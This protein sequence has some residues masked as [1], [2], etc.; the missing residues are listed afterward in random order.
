M[1]NPKRTDAIMS[2]WTIRH[3]RMHCASPT[4]RPSLSRDG[5]LAV[6]G[7]KEEAGLARLLL[8]DMGSWGRNDG[9]SVTNAIEVL[10][11]EAHQRMV[12]GFNIALADTQIVEL[13]GSGAFDLVLDLGD[14]RG[15]RHQPLF[16]PRRDVLPRS[17]EAFLA[18]GGDV[19]QAMLARVDGL[20]EVGWAG[21]EG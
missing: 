8:A 20:R 19:A 11:R 2:R 3:L 4:A 7:V 13:D 18:W 21:V 15:A 10:V 16:A 5:I 6:A 1:M 17:R 9:A 12:A 14:G